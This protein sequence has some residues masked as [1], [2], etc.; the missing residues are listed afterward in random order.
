[1]T[2]IDYQWSDVWLLQS[3]I[4]GGGEKG[5]TLYNII[6]T[7]D[8]LNHAIFTNDELES[9]F[10]RLTAGALVIEK[11]KRFFPTKKAKA[12]YRAADEK[13]GSIYTVRERLGKRLNATPYDPN[14]KYPNPNNNLTYPGFSSKAAERAIEKWHSEARRLMKKT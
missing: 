3:M 13:G 6:S 4:I 8:A 11:E 1:M 9:G 12:I 2:T 5:A 14:Q 10:S 7:G